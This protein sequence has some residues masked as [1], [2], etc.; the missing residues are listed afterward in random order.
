M[1]SMSAPKAQSPTFDQKGFKAD[2][3]ELFE[4]HLKPARTS[5]SVDIL[6]H[7]PYAVA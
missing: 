3:P 7:R 4:Q 6:F 1:R 5:V 2:H